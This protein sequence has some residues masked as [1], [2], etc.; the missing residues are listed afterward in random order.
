MKRNKNFDK[1]LIDG[2][3][4][5]VILSLGRLLA[6]FGI[7]I[8]AEEPADVKLH[9]V[10]ETEFSRKARICAGR[11]GEITVACGSLPALWRTILHL[12]KTRFAVERDFTLKAYMKELSV[13]L[14]C[15]RNAVPN[16]AH[17]K[18]TVEYLALLGYTRLLL[19]TE[20]VFEIENRP[21]FG[22]LRGR[23][24]TAE[25]K[26]IDA[27]C[28]AFGI[29]LIPCV[30]TLAHL[31]GIFRYGFFSDIHDAGDVLLCEEEKTYAFLENLFASLRKMFSS[32]LVHI[33]MDEAQKMGT[34][35][36]RKRFPRKEP[37]EVY[38]RHH[39]RVKAI[40]EKYGF[41]CMLWGD[42]LFQ[43]DDVHID[44]ATEVIYWDYYFDDTDHYRIRLD[45]YEK[46]ADNVSFA[47]GAYKW[48]G[49]APANRQ[50]IKNSIPALQACLEKEI[51]H[52]MVTLWGDDGGEAS[53][54]SVFPV[55]CLFSDFFW[56]GKEDES[57]ET[58]KA[59]TGLT[60]EQ[61]LLSDTPNMLHDDKTYRL[62]NASKY[63]FYQDV[64]AGIFDGIVEDDYPDMFKYRAEELAGTAKS[65][66]K[67]GYIF[68]TLSALCNVLKGKCLLGKKI[69][70]HYRKGDKTALKNCIVDLDETIKN[71]RMFFEAYRVQ[72][73]LENK[74]S[75]FEVQEHRIGGLLFRLENV[76][77]EISDFID[78]RSGEIEFL[79][80][81]IL[82]VRLD[83]Y[84]ENANDILF[85]EY[86]KIVTVNRN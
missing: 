66:E 82:P 62:N 63:L 86:A 3:G 50:S 56:F 83:D 85:N 70:S 28:S 10:A 17:V 53:V 25:I 48:I 46:K 42:M 26:E 65:S 15:S 45:E 5:K 19:Y 29:E 49:F 72:W 47:G 75:G 23:Y 11:E 37:K 78:G 51:E 69:R 22:Y 44:G 8:V 1:I 52:V 71:V 58:L 43:F 60:K 64:L 61:W 57:G 40:A 38:L 12:V 36:Y 34:G 54:F 27:Y 73:N 30:Q 79:E 9:L 35:S 33:G 68:K 2:A 32:R 14:D 20:D 41:S 4:E 59:L 39:S 77:R 67:F 76:K 55:L 18:K 7:T 24:T 80:Q 81:E 13:M 74:F 31:D 84:P 21:Y 6:V 16:I